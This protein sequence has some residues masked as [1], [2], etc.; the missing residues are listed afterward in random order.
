MKT[1]IHFSFS[2]LSVVGPWM[3]FK[4]KAIGIRFCFV[5]PQEPLVEVGIV[6]AYLVGRSISDNK[7]VCFGPFGE[8]CPNPSPVG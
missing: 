6:R 7:Y 5:K 8:V 1:M 2:T 4:R 3:I